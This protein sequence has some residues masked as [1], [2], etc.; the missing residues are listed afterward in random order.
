MNDLYFSFLVFFQHI[1]SSTINV[2]K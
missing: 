2:I 1:L